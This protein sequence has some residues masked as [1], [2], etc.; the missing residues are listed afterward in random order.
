MLARHV[1]HVVRARGAPAMLCKQVRTV[2]DVRKPAQV[3]WALWAR[4]RPIFRP[5]RAQ[6]AI[7]SR[8]DERAPA[9][10][11]RWRHG[12]RLSSQI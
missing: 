11:A 5:G 10:Q 9:E 1:W 7:G 8:L 4:A 2:Y 6:E 3:V 12:R